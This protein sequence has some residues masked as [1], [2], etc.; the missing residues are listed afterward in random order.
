MATLVLTVVGGVLGGPVGAALGAVVGQQADAVLFKPKGRE[1]PRLNDLRLQA[2]AYGMQI[3]QIFGTMRVAGSVIWATD[4]IERRSKSGG[5]KGRPSVAEYS[6]A[7]SFAVALSSRQILAIKRIWADGNLLRGGDGAF[8]ERCLFRWYDGDA[9]QA[10]DPL[11]ASALGPESTSAFRGLAYAVFEELELARFGN[12]IPALTFEIEGDAGGAT[13]GFVGGVLLKDAGRFDSALMLGGYAAS[14]D[15][16]RG[17]MGPLI[18]TAGMRLI[19]DGRAWRIGGRGA[20]SGAVGI[21]GFRAFAHPVGE[22]DIAERKRNASSDLPCAIQM[23]HYDPAR[24]YQTGQQ[25]AVIAGGV[26]REQRIDLPAV[27]DAGAAWALAGENA[28]AASDGR[29]T[30]SL[31]GDLAAMALPVGAVVDLGTMGAWRLTRRMIRGAAVGLDLQRHQPLAVT[32]GTADGGSAVITPDWPATPGVVRLFDLPNLSEPAATAPVIVAAAAGAND[33][34]R[35]ADLW[36]VADESAAPIA[37]G[38]VRP[39]LAL[40]V[41]VGVL[42]SGPSMLFDDRS[43]ILVDLVNPAMDLESVDDAALLNGA[44]RAMV[45]AELV[46]FARATPE[47][48]G[49]WRLARLLRGRAGT[50]GAL[51][52]HGPGEGFVLLDDAALLTLPPVL[53]SAMGD[54]AMVEW[55]T[56]GSSAMSA[57]PVP[58]MAR[59]MIPLTPVHGACRPGADG[60]VQLSWI[61]R[62]RTG[63]GWRDAVDA[64]LGEAQELY[65]IS[66]SEP[67]AGLGGWQCTTPT[68][69]LTAAEYAM[70]SPGAEVE[71]RQVGDFAVSA[72]LRLSIT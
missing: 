40:G 14:G 25:S 9:D 64:P 59:A 55:A 65:R 69:A 61:R 11:I 3:P 29:E 44:N 43:E 70:L 72:P 49:R 36:W 63:Q 50:E 24:D 48:G 41:M 56:R 37:L 5:G 52:T 53:T 51:D 2:S 13:A 21:A 16:V 39:A 4:L 18:D 35:G 32:A 71:I 66:L 17:A 23:R 15:G 38:T 8:K 54:G 57:L 47:G 46:Q 7:A 30:I 33:G 6:Y 27:L 28:L 34:W 68:F 58:R 19:S 22:R 60:G 20:G 10:P 26:A 62:S 1:G 45:G 67:V 12:R 31:V 42:G